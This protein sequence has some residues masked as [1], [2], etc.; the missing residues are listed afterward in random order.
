MHQPIGDC[1]K[2]NTTTSFM[3][4]LKTAVQM[5]IWLHLAVTDKKKMHIMKKIYSLV[6]NKCDRITDYNP[7]VLTGMKEYDVG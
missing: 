6:M 5:K 1:L 7:T 2:N 3:S 4:V